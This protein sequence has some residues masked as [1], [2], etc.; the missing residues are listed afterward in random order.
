ML[1][2]EAGAG[3]TRPAIMAAKTPALYICPAVLRNQVR[4]TAAALHFLP[5]E[6]QVVNKLTDRL[7]K[8]AK[9]IICSYE[10]ISSG[11]IW[12]Q[13]FAREWGSLICDEAH[14]L[15]NTAS[16]RTRAIY[17]ARVDSKASLFRKARQ[18]VLLTGTP[19]MNAPDELWSHLSRLQYDKLWAK[20]IK[21]KEEF[22]AK[23]CIT[24]DTPY[25]AV[26]TG[27][28][29][30]VELQ[31]MLEGFMWRVT[32]EQ[33][34]ELPLLTIDTI[35]IP[36]QKI[37]L[38]DVPP[39]ALAELDDILTNNDFT[40]ID[41]IQRLA[42]HLATLRRRIGL[43]KAAH[44]AKLVIEEL[45]S[46][47][48]K[49]AIF[50]VHTDVINELSTAFSKAKI[51]NVIF[52]GKRTQAQKDQAKYDFI[53]SPQVRVFIGQITAAGTGLDGLQAVCSRGYILE[54]AWTPAVNEQAIA[55]LDRGGQTKKVRSSYVVLENSI[56]TRI[57]LSL[58][59]KEKLIN[60]VMKK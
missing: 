2:W 29:N 7:S 35:F 26:V 50:A 21:S 24:N 56:D 20:N 36:P 33:V 5:D 16:K 55:R 1:A 39:E 47:V 28:R 38:S 22:V 8:T 19:M 12:K 37:D 41:K 44:F 48:E 52:D 34:L 46:G 57:V 59:R 53:N 11:L 30:V 27:V 15:K 18:V 25:G 6:I 45:N 23:F 54:A 4:D 10:A 32:K 43:A 51:T 17:G 58:R 9:L 3:K 13:A 31:N 60:K 42:P 40:D 14:Y 49:I